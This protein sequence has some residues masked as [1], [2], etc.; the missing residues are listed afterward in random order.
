MSCLRVVSLRRF[1]ALFVLPYLLS[2]GDTIAATPREQVAEGMRR[3]VAGD[4]AGSIEAFDAAAAADESMVPRLWQ[5]GISYY[6]AGEFAKG[7]DQFVVHKTVNP[8]DVENAAWHYLC[9]A[10][11]DGVE[12]A[13]QALL[14]ID[15]RRDTRVP[16]AEVYRLYAGE[17]TVALVLA[18]AEADGTPRAEM[19]AQL[20]LGLYYE[21]AGQTNL[22]REHLVRAAAVDL[23]DHYMRN[24][25]RV[26]VNER[27][28]G[29]RDG[30][31]REEGE[32]DSTD[33]EEAGEA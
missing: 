4:V 21:A 15:T 3:F 32:A 13:R 18:A 29:D 30:R 7:R 12:A 22:A 5:R 26:H 24:V 8:H 25:A 14:E 16:L 11:I 28:W 23:P 9:V 20:Y 1:A 6:Y 19:Y 17:G 2:V 27:G 33:A 31:A 10:R